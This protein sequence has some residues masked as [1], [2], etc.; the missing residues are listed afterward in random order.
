MYSNGNLK[1]INRSKEG[2]EVCVWSISTHDYVIQFDK[3]IFYSEKLQ[4]NNFTK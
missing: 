3:G 4:G 1:L 2:A